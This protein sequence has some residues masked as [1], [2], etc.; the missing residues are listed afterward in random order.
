M[1]VFQ[2]IRAH[3]TLKTIKN[4]TIKRLP[5]RFYKKFTEKKKLADACTM[6]VI[7]KKKKKFQFDNS[8][9]Y[10]LR[11]SEFDFRDVSYTDD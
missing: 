10:R 2:S 1:F 7:K 9:S 11:H 3:V 5:S 8:S 4:K 6:Y